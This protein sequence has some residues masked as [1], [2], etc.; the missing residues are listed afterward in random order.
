MT[1]GAD[2]GLREQPEH[3]L[4]KLMVAGRRVP[5]LIRDPREGWSP[6]LYYLGPDEEL[7]DEQSPSSLTVR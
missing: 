3:Q 6:D 1:R 5:R 7:C 4:E 2:A